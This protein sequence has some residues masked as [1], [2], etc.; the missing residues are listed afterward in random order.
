MC[1]RL[2]N[3]DILADGTLKRHVR[4]AFAGR[5]KEYL[6]TVFSE[7]LLPLYNAVAIGTKSSMSWLSSNQLLLDDLKGALKACTEPNPDDCVMLREAIMVRGSAQIIIEGIMVSI[8]LVQAPPYHD[9]CD[10]A[11]LYKGR[12]NI[13]FLNHIPTDVCRAF[14]WAHKLW[15][16]SNGRCILFCLFFLCSERCWQTKNVI[17]AK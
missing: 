1:K 12:N 6:N 17:K 2:V 16:G 7:T 4:E 10:F 11:K 5:V 3:M 15:D 9:S 14:P 13:I 8:G